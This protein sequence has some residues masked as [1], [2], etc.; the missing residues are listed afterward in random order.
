MSGGEQQMLRDRPRA[1][2]AAEARSCSTSRRWAS[3]RSSSSE[4]F[5]IV[6]EINEQG[7]P[8]LLVEQNALMALDVAEPRLRAARP[9]AIALEGPA[10]E[11]QDERAGA[12]DLPRR[13][14]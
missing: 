6:V 12:Q 7:T 2:G 4:I 10:A 11:L 3:R 8:V 14:S 9:G 13:A 1:D 5:E